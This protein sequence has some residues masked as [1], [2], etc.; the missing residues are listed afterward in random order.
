M[1]LADVGKMFLHTQNT[2][3]HK[4]D[5]YPNTLYPFLKTENGKKTGLGSSKEQQQGC[6]E[7]LKAWASVF[8]ARR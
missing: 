3:I 2:Q 5:L 8:C 7:I 6:M 4:A 1:P